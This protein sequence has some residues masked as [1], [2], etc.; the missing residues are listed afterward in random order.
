VDSDRKLRTEFRHALD[1]VTPPAPWLRTTV[2]E[3]LRQKRTRSWRVGW[4]R[5][6]VVLRLPRFSQKMAAAAL[7]VVVAAAAV[8]LVL[9]TRHAVNQPAPAGHASPEAMPMGTQDLRAGTYV[10]DPL[11]DA[12]GKPFPNV[13]VTVPDGW[14]SYQGFAVERRTGTPRELAVSVWSVADVYADG[15]HWLGS[16]IHPGPTVDELA[17]ALAARPLR[18]ATTPVAVSFDGYQG[19]Y[20]EW[21]VPA[22]INF[23]ECDGGIFQSWIAAPGDRYQQGPGQVDRLWILDVEGHRVVIDATYM[24]GSTTQDRE[25]LTQV[26]DSIAFQR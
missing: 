2:K 26:V 3:A 21:S 23:S 13:L 20:M 7:I 19:K 9:A 15:C 11:F 6:I 12:S 14:S 4:R 1:V 17:A 24:P 5:P 16:T 18:N 8:E 25:E 10:Y 22:D